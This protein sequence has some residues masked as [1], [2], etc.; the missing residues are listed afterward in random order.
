MPKGKGHKSVR[1]IKKEVKK[2]KKDQDKRKK[3]ATFEGPNK[4]GGEDL[5]LS[6][7]RE[8]RSI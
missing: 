7:N 4:N 3:N 8:I 1:T 2:W 5:R 6:K